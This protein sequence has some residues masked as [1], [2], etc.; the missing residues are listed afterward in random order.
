M[1]LEAANC[2]KK[3]SVYNTQKDENPA[4]RIFL[5]INGGF[6]V[7][8]NPVTILNLIEIGRVLFKV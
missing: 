2:K 3:M 8:Q 6:I 5:K 1:H 4:G 7:K